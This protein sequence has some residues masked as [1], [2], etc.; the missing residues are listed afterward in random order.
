MSFLRLLLF[1]TL[2][3]VVGTLKILIYQSLSD[4]PD[5]KFSGILTDVLVERGHTVDNLLMEWNS[6]VTSNGT[7]NARRIIRVRNKHQNEN[8]PLDHSFF[9]TRKEILCRGNIYQICEFKLFLAFLSNR[10]MIEE[11]KLEKY[12]VG[13]VTMSDSCGFGIFYLIGIPATLA[14]SLSSQEYNVRELLG[15]PTPTSFSSGI[16][17]LLAIK[18]IFRYGRSVNFYAKS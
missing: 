10:P 14:Y 5:I 2:V 11:L 4:E 15:I 3:P 17:E 12:D 16:F 13:L 9:Q 18:P 6:N 7:S 8:F 1:L